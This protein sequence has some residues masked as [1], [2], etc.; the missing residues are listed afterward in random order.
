[1]TLTI[2]LEDLHG[3]ISKEINDCSSEGLRKEEQTKP[4]IC[5]NNRYPGREE[6]NTD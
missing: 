1:V 5:R 4:H 3:K 6:Q 2:A